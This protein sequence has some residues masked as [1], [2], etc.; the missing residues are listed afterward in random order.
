MHIEIDEEELITAVVNSSSFEDGVSDALDY[1]SIAESV[2]DHLDY[3]QVADNISFPVDE[4]DLERS[5]QDVEERLESEIDNLKEQ[6]AD[7]HALTGLI[8]SLRFDNARQN[9]RITKLEDC[10]AELNKPL[11]KR[12]WGRLKSLRK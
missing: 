2:V 4:D 9:E 12:I 8:E 5:C 1:D 3:D 10:I 11:W 7:C 6:F